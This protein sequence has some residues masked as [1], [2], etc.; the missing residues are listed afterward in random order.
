MKGYFVG[1]IHNDLVN[2]DMYLDEHFGRVSYDSDADVI[3]CIK[4][5]KSITK[6]LNKLDRIEKVMR[7]NR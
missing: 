7:A 2:V 3:A 6:R 5:M 4:D 1:K